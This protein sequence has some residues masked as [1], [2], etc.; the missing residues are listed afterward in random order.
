M[1]RSLKKEKSFIYYLFVI[2]L[3]LRCC[4]GFSLVAVCRL[5]VAGR[6]GGGDLLLVQRTG[7]RTHRLQQLWLWGS[8]AQA[9]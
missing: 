7:S 6:G 2:V 5:R 3:G 9:Q 1:T 4:E 8:R